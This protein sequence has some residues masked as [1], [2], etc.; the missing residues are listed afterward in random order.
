MEI[1]TGISQVNPS[2]RG[3]VA[4]IGNFDGVHLGHQ[5]VLEHTRSIAQSL[6]AQSGVMTFA[7][8]PRRFFAP[9]SP[10]FE[11]MG[12]MQKRQAL[13]SLGMDILF[14][15]AFNGELAAL[16]AESF[17]CDIL[18]KGFGLR[19]VIVGDDFH[20]GKNRQG[21]PEMLC[22]LGKSYGFDV[23]IAQE[24]AHDALRVS[25]SEIRAALKE[26]NPRL[27]AQMMGRPYTY[28]SAVLH[29]EKRGRELGYPT[30]NMDISER[31]LPRFGIYA[32]RARIEGDHALKGDYDGVASLG[33]RPTF[34]GDAPNLE[35]YLF[36]FKGDIYSAELSVELIEFLR[37]EEKFT[38]L[39]A[40]I[41][42]MD[43][44]CVD[45]RRALGAM[46]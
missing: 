46:S 30:A 37:P 16:S 36:D 41:A 33:V 35:T 9:Q 26:G 43:Q 20:F 39:E 32:V 1:I 17:A 14:E 4:A 34:D 22:D 31:H 2:Q 23:T 3:A 38:S 11:L 18:A 28:S 19:H 13:A 25:S 44:D 40:L 5:A 6:G 10:A 15:L 45:A 8:H 42:Q 27:A 12:Q 21:T 24:V 29:G 7:P